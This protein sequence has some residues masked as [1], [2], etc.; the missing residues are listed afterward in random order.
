MFRQLAPKPIDPKFGSIFSHE[1]TKKWNRFKLSFLNKDTI[2][3]IY[4]NTLQ[5]FPIDDLN[6]LKMNPLIQNF[7]H[8]LQLHVYKLRQLHTC[9][10]YTMI[11]SFAVTSLKGDICL[12]MWV[13]MFSRA[14]AVTFRDCT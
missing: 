9:L 10:Q 6:K 8:D 7:Q 14:S 3:F 5:N 12:S 4:L 13:S 2:N 1:T 11:R